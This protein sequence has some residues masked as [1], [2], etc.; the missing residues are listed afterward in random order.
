MRGHFLANQNLVLFYLGIIVR[1]EVD[2]EAGKDCLLLRFFWKVVDNFD[3]FL[4][5]WH[6]V[7]SSKLITVSENFTD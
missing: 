1:N 6:E 4:D 3:G 7:K 2:K 5:D